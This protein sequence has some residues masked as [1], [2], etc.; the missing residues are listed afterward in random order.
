MLDR[1]QNFYMFALIEACLESRKIDPG[2]TERFVASL[3]KNAP[4]PGKL[5]ASVAESG[6]HRDVECISAAVRGSQTVGPVQP[7]EN[8]VAMNA[9]PA[10]AEAAADCPENAGLR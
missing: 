8:A 6:D 3:A 7:P 9:Y 2:V 1:H 10:G 5:I 4:A